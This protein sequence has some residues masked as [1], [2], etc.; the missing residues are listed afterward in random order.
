ML[1]VLV[2]LS[3]QFS[4]V[5][6][7]LLFPVHFPLVFSLTLYVMVLDAPKPKDHTVKFN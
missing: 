5:V 1:N 6:E 4:E 3:L 7:D 2:Y